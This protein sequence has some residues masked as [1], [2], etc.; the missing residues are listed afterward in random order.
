M[1]VVVHVDVEDATD[2]LEDVRERAADLRPVFR[3]AQKELQDIYVNHF[4]SRGSGRWAPLSAEY[5]SW[6]SRNFP[7]RPILVRSGRLFR[8]IE[9]FT[10][11]EINK[12]SAVFGTDVPEAKFHQYGTWSMPK[13]EIIFEPPLFAKK[14]A[15]DMSKYITEGDN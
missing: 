11:S 15:S 3:K 5:G 12:Q 4:T 9:R 13:R 1:R 14:L 6:K 8:S 10:I 7:G 2:L